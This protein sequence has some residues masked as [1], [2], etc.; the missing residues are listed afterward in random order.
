[1]VTIKNLIP[2]Y[3]MGKEYKVPDTLTIMKAMEYVGYRFIRGCGCR[4]GICGACSTV[5]R[6]KDDYKIKVAL[7]CQT[8]VEEGMYLVQ[9]PFYPANKARY[10][11]EE[12]KPNIADILSLY[13]ELSRCVSCNSCTKICPQELDVMDYVQAALRGDIKTSA[14]LSFECI[15]CG[16]CASRCPAEEVQYYI[17]IL[18]RRLY[19]KHLLKKASH[20]KN[21]LKEIEEGKFNKELEQIKALPKEKL[22]ELYHTREI[23]QEAEIIKDQ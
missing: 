21:R 13:P 14:K 5:Y 19:G 11:I 17:G 8:I 9:L 7:A 10:K 4:A 23:E 16:L 20:L 6:K 15:M 12:L 2:I 22:M 18:S 1:M 3:I